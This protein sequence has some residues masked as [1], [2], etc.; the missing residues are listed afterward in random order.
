MPVLFYQTDQLSLRIPGRCRNPRLK[1]FCLEIVRS[2]HNNVSCNQGVSGDSEAMVFQPIPHICT[3]VR[4]LADAQEMHI[5]LRHIVLNRIHIAFPDFPVALQKPFEL[6]LRF[7]EFLTGAQKD[8]PRNIKIPVAISRKL[9]IQ[10]SSYLPIFPKNICIVK[11]SVA[12]DGFALRGLPLKIV[13]QMLQIQL[14]QKF[15]IGAVVEPSEKQAHSVGSA[16]GL[17]FQHRHFLA[18]QL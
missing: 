8:R 10:N 7:Q 2:L 16:N 4:L 14:F 13:A 17:R 5:T 15:R 3:I 11:V 12:K 18:W 1:Q 9:K 6:L